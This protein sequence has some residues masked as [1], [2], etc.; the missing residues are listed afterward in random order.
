MPPNMRAMRAGYIW[1][2]R[3][4]QKLAAASDAVA[5]SA[6]G[7]AEPKNKVV[8]NVHAPRKSPVKSAAPQDQDRA[9]HR[10]PVPGEGV[11]FPPAIE[12]LC[13]GHTDG[14]KFIHNP[15]VF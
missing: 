2:G 12:M 11:V 7:T 5:D 6:A 4:G 9:D 8:A 15:L 1:L 10:Y 14:N 3:V 13:P